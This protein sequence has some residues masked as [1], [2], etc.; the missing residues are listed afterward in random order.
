ML[1]ADKKR[2]EGLLAAVGAK[3]GGAMAA[4]SHWIEEQ[5]GYDFQRTRLM[6]DLVKEPRFAAARAE[7]EVFGQL[8]DLGNPQIPTREAAVKTL[9]AWFAE[10]PE[11]APARAK[12][13]LDLAAKTPPKRRE[14]RTAALL[15]LPFVDVMPGTYDALV[16]QLCSVYLD[17][18]E[19]EV[20]LAALA[21]MPVASRDECVAVAI[22]NGAVH[23]VTPGMLALASPKLRAR[24]D[25][26]P[27]T[28]PTRKKTTE[29]TRKKKTTAAKPKKTTLPKKSNPP[30]KATPPQR[31]KRTASRK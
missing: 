11:K 19:E 27:A 25:A 13:L 4:L 14:W 10:H 9:A 1:S 24:I 6:G 31:P 30:G 20:V 23:R 18:A 3:K 21:R 7:V 8:L 12:Q 29:P 2:L 16:A 26:K 15:C 5:P 17:V 22:A 28:E